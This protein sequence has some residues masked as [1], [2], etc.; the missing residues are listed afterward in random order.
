M[1][2]ERVEITADSLSLERAVR[3]LVENAL[4]HTPAG[5]QIVIRAGADQAEAR[6]EVIDAG[7]GI[8][9][10]N[11]PHLFD[12]FY[13]VDTARTRAHGGAGLGLSI[14]KAIMEAHGGS[15]SVRSKLGAGSTFTLRL[16]VRT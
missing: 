10:E 8:A 13:R 16:P 5:E 12:R 14:V 15:V 3:N 1:L 4:R 9:P 7:V 6:I 2:P 11:L